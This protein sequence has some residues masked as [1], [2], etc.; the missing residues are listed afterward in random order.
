MISILNLFI[1]YDVCDCYDLNINDV[2]LIWYLHDNMMLI[3]K[4]LI[5]K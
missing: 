4:Y 2:V 5:L 3:W 1:F